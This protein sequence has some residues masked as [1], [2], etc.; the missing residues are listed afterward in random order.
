MEYD[1]LL[2]VRNNDDKTWVFAWNSERFMVPPSQERLVP[3]AAVVA[4]LG[5]PRSQMNPS[6]FTPEGGGT[7][8][9]IPD[10]PSEIRRL[11][12]LYGVYTD[13]ANDPSYLDG[14]EGVTLMD[15]LP[16][17]EVFNLNDEEPEAIIF[18]AD[19]PNCTN[20]VPDNQDKTQNAMLQRQLEQLRRR[21]IVMEQLLKQATGN[22]DPLDE[23][24]EV[25]VDSPEPQRSR[26]V[27]AS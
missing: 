21:Q 25:T 19:D 20:F 6:S 3:F 22:T 9:T 7:S 10:R 5:D 2:R 26:S 16:K 1:S 23:G 8:I 13:G 15:R 18:P 11:N 12:T 24:E 14:Q 4:Y 27:K 17:V